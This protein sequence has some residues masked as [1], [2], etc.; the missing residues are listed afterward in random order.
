MYTAFTVKNFRGF[1]ELTVGP[2]GRV[3]LIAGKNNVGKTALLEA[4]WWHSGPDLPDIGMRVDAFRGLPLHDPQEFLWDLFL[5]FDPHT[6]IELGAVGDWGDGLRQLRVTI[7]ERKTTRVALGEEAVGGG[8]RSSDP[9]AGAREELAL[10]YIDET[11]NAFASRGWRIVQQAGLIVQEGMEKEQQNVPGRPV[12]VYIPARRPP[13]PDEDAGR[14]GKIQVAGAEARI[15][16]ILRHVDSRI[17][18]LLIIPIRDVPVVHAD[19][20]LPRLIPLPLLGDGMARLLSLAVSFDTA[21]G[22][23][24]LVDE[25]E[26]GFHYTVMK[27]VWASIAEL[28]RVYDVQV[29]ATTH[30]E[31]C[32]R[33]AHEAFQE[34]SPYDFRL[35]RLERV[36]K[37][38]RVV[39]YS[40]QTLGAALEAGIE[41]R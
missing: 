18:R 21:K 37:D 16:E 31:E 11:G 36:D 8:L 17:N 23:L 39:T 12:S 10:E 19:I 28:A 1:R 4:L 6:T 34:K 27:Q 15:I 9:A 29:F 30:S 40:Q 32:V 41:V 2:L 35:H 26:N 33:S 20:G 5:G 14:F 3:N 38:L 7:R 22:G 24:L 25:V 13:K